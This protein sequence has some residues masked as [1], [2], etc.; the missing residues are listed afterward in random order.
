VAHD[1]GVSRYV[2]DPAAP[3]EPEPPT[4]LGVL[5]MPTR[6]PRSLA[7]LAAGT[8]R[9]TTRDIPIP[10]EY[11][12]KPQVEL[13][14]LLADDPLRGRAPGTM[15][16]ATSDASLGL[17]LCAFGLHR[18]IRVRGLLPVCARCRWEAH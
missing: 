4:D 15:R 11:Q 3:L 10:P 12:A 9:P 7:D 1:R 16:M 2:A 17:V 5:D 8:N 14:S 13:P 18:K 6:K